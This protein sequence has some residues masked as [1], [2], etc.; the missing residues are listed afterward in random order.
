MAVI[1]RLDYAIANPI[2]D[3][4]KELDRK[5]SRLEKVMMKDRWTGHRRTRKFRRF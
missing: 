3:L 2:K 4:K 5:I 1:S